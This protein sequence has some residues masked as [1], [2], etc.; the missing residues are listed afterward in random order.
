MLKLHQIVSLTLTLKFNTVK[1][2]HGSL[3]F[4]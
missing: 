1:L 2:G 3:F 4:F